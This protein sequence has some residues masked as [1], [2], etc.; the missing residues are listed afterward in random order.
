M[1]ENER[2]NSKFENK[3]VK[4]ELFLDFNKQL[5]RAILQCDEL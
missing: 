4:N 5:I 3:E 2:C 1:T